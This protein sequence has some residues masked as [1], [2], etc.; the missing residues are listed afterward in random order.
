M[1]NLKWNEEL[2]WDPKRGLRIVEDHQPVALG[3]Y[4]CLRGWGHNTWRKRV[5][6]KDGSHTWVLLDPKDPLPTRIR[7]EALLLGVQ[8]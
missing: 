1:S 3:T 8:V 5:K 7:V 4:Q 2:R 6:R